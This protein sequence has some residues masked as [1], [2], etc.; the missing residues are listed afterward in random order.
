[1]I[2]PVQGF[3]G[4]KIR[5]CIVI[6]GEWDEFS[7][8]YINDA[9]SVTVSANGTAKSYNVYIPYPAQSNNPLTN[10]LVLIIQVNGYITLASRSSSGSATVSVVMNGTTLYSTTFSNTNNQ[11]IV[12]RII[13]YSSFPSGSQRNWYDTLQINVALGSG[14]SS[15]T[16]TQ[17]QYMFGVLLNGGSSGLTVQIPVFQG[18]AYIND[19][20]NIFTSP[21]LANAF[22]LGAI[23]AHYDP[24]GI[25]TGQA[26]YN[27]NSG[28][29]S[30]VANNTNS[31][32]MLRAMPTTISSN[33]ASG[34][35]T[36]TVGANQSVLI[37]YF[38][39]SIIINGISVAKGHLREDLYV[40]Y[41]QL[42]NPDNGVQFNNDRF[43]LAENLFMSNSNLT[44]S[45]TNFI[46]QT[47]SVG[48]LP[49][50]NYNRSI[51]QSYE[52]QSPTKQVG[53]SYLYVLT[54]TIPKA[55][56]HIDTMA[57]SYSESDRGQ[58]MFGNGG[59]DQG[60]MAI[61]RMVFVEVE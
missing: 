7:A 32:W 1:M 21:N 23:I 42:G 11:L 37:G 39:F 38:L 48:S 17:V 50:G 57:Y 54:N 60:G 15:V 3:G 10:Y 43:A 25:T 18:I 2:A 9:S 58:G 35:L 22:G 4:Q 46:N 33:M 56:I 16:I 44:T 12:N 26:T 51:F 49:S 55:L 34:T 31:I 30:L 53:N 36:I 8:L 14:T 19:D 41:L 40:R 27:A 45:L 28:Q 5:K 61:A 47:G 6:G 20:P 29:V 13:P 24:F 52:N 59:F